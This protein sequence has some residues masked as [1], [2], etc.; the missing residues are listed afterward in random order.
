MHALSL[1]KQLRDQGFDV[2]ALIP[3]STPRR[4]EC[5]R[6]VLHSF[7]SEMEIDNL[8]EG[9]NDCLGCSRD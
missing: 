3:S 5:L 1:A 9:L 7:N 6:F 8:I 4:K 2:R